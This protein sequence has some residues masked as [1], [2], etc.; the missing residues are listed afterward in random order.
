LTQLTDF[1]IFG[2]K[3]TY[4]VSNQKT[5]YGAP[6]VTCASA[7]KTRSTKIAFFTCCISALPEFN[8]S[9]FDFFNLVDSR[10]IVT[11]L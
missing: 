9:L 8:Q 11:L 7:G 6:Q 5:L 4:K 2:R 10:L 1:D 3:V